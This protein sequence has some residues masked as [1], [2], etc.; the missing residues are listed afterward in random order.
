MR[1]MLAFKHSAHDATANAPYKTS[2]ILD[3][4]QFHGGVFSRF[5]APSTGGFERISPSGA[6]QGCIAFSA[7]AGMPL[8]KTPFKA[9]GAQDQSGI[10]VS[11]LFFG[12][13]K[14]RNPPA[15]AG[16]GIQTRP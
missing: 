4:F 10:R 14:K 16:I 1:R 6:M 3:A 9:F 12:Q 11:F 2:Q 7:G 15:G 8:R 5:A 13:A